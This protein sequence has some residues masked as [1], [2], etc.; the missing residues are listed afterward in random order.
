[1]GQGLFSLPGVG[2]ARQASSPRRRQTG[3][4]LLTLFLGVSGMIRL[5]NGIGLAYAET[6]KVQGPVAAAAPMGA[7]TAGSVA[8]GTSAAGATCPA[9]AG[10]LAMLQSLKSREERLAEQEANAAEK[11]QTLTLARA[12]V[13]QKIAELRA[14][15]AKLASTIAMADQA[16]DKDVSQ[17]VTVYESMKPKEA[18]RLFSE[19][20]PKFA[21]GFLAKMRPEVAAAILSGLDPQKAYL[22]SVT[23][24]GR[25]AEAPKS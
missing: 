21:A 17:L 16:A 23:F 13:D 5:G 25:N 20:D 24:A 15:E 2:L 11:E 14:A 12:A 6:A 4:C 3:L 19:M 22:I 10:A 1:M 9:D 18:A 8:N 7:D